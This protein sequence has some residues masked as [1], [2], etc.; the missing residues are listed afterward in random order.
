AISEKSRVLK[1]TKL[2]ESGREALRSMES[3]ELAVE[4]V[5]LYGKLRELK[6][7]SKDDEGSGHFW[8]ELMEDNGRKWRIKF[9]DGELNKV[10]RLFRKQVSVFGDATYFKT[11]LPRVDA[12]SITEERRPDYV[13]AFD[14]FR[15]SYAE[16]FEER[17]P[18]DI[19]ND[20]RE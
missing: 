16:V 10:L 18:K 1:K 17:D 15:E 6:D 13:G 3:A 7:F 2:G 19:L 9:S 5:T 11:K 8:G 4:A 20:I 14:K 12:K